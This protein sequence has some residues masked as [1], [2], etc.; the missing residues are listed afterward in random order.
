MVG[1]NGDKKKKYGKRKKV[2]VAPVSGSKPKKVVEKSVSLRGGSGGFSASLNKSN[3]STGRR[4]SYSGNV[5]Q[6][7]S[8]VRASTTGK[9]GTTF[10]ASIDKPYQGKPNLSAGVTFKIGKQRKG[11]GKK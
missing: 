8:G 11:Y 5:G 9:R 3:T 7:S 4:T 1:D 2:K 6:F 10:S